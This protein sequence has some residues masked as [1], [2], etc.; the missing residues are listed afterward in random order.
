MSENKSGTFHP[1]T[2]PRVPSP[3]FGKPLGHPGGRR[4]SSDSPFVQGW[5]RLVKC[6]PRPGPPLDGRGLWGWTEGHDRVGT[7]R[8]RPVEP[9]S[10][11]TPPGRGL[12]EGPRVRDRRTC[13]GPPENCLWSLGGCLL[14]APPPSVMGRLGPPVR[15]RCR[16]L[17]LGPVLPTSSREPTLGASGPTRSGREPRVKEKTV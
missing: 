10:K 14:T 16:A 7:G 8:R 11:G 9:D 15:K 2:S 13:S 6:V 5:V 1:R 12:T 17:C 3:V 4:T